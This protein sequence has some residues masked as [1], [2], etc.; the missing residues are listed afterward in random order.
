MDPDAMRRVVVPRYGEVARGFQRELC[1][2]RVEE[3]AEYL[4]R[5]NLP[6]P[7]GQIAHTTDTGEELLVEGQH[8]AYGSIA[9]GK[10]MS[11]QIV[12]CTRD[13]ALTMFMACNAK[14]QR[15]RGNHL[16]VVSGNRAGQL[17]RKLAQSYN[18]GASQA[19]SLMA[20][21]GKVDYVDRGAKL[22]EHTKEKADLILSIWTECDLWHYYEEGNTAPT[23][24]SALW[25]STKLLRAIGKLARDYDAKT[26]RQ[27]LL[28]F[29]DRRGS[30]FRSGRTLERGYRS[31]TMTQLVQ[32]LDK[33]AKACL[34]KEAK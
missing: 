9:A 3:I 22:A 17:G 7:P 29:R 13:E 10:S 34:R 4:R 32:A 14:A 27:I 30:I 19:R 21:L 8:R 25:S 31:M 12:E 1:E 24:A 23:P 5:Y 11:F 26:L 16:H 2:S 6:L 28:G 15:V 18:V 33:Y 20:G